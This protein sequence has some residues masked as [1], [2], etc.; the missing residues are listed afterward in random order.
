[1]A[2]KKLENLSMKLNKVV[3]VISGNKLLLSLRDTFLMA[4]APLMIAGFAIMINSVFLD[5][6]GIIFGESGLRLGI[7]M[8]GNLDAWLASG[9]AATLYSLQ[10]YFNLFST[11]TMA[12]NTILVVVG[13]AYFLTKRFFPKNRDPYISCFYALSTFFI[14]LPWTKT[15]D[16]DGK[17]TV[18]N[19]LN[20]DFLGQKGIFA[21][22]II[23]GITVFIFNKMMQKNIKIKMPATVPPAVAKS[24][25]S[26]VPGLI[27]MSLFVIVAGISAQFAQT[28][29][30]ELLLDLLQ[31][32]ALAVAKTSYFAATAI[33][34]QPIL[35]W[36]GIHASSVWG[37]IFG[38][39][40]DIAS[41]ENVMGTAQ[42]LYSTLFMNFSIVAS[43]TLTLVPLIAIKL[44]SKREESKSLIK[45]A[46]VP[47][48]FNISEPVTFGLP[49]ALNPIYLIPYAGSW[50]LS[51]FT[52]QILTMIGFIPIVT[53]N[54]PWTVPPFISG[55]LYTGSW[56][57]VVAQVIIIVLCVL[58][59][60][61]FVK[62]ANRMSYKQSEG[63]GE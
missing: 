30:P 40:W 2:S 56:T 26:M 50:L 20:S 63:N 42:H 28:S 5:P 31:K 3:G 34:T 14:C 4:A 49:I 24:F 8:E 16:I 48:I 37:P 44:F 25:E 45:I 43:G 18:V 51:F 17:S 39:T 55:L 62:I 38:M 60:M 33:S 47:A 61:P 41:N 15:I 11:G 27:A 53:N 35:Q 29:I 12:I 10:N 46:A 13:F 58:L 19:V 21:G 36:F 6:N 52:A 9:F 7:L 32:P 54:V 59:W 23:T 22:L 57:G 1:M